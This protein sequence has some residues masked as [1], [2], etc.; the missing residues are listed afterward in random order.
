MTVCSQLFAKDAKPITPPSTD[1]VDRL[2]AIAISTRSEALRSSHRN[3]T[4]HHPNHCRLGLAGR[5]GLDS[6]LHWY[7]TYEPMKAASCLVSH[8]KSIRTAVRAALPAP[9]EAVAAFELR[10]AMAI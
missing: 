5:E 2:R 10:T 1:G 9:C 6:C 8:P 3:I 4:T 7:Y